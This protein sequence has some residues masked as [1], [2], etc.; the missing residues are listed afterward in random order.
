MVFA[1]DTADRFNA[2]DNSA[3]RTVFNSAVAC[4]DYTAHIAICFI[5]GIDNIEVRYNSRIRNTAEKTEVLGLCR[6]LIVFHINARHRVAVAVK[7]TLVEFDEVFI[8]AV[9]V[10]A[11]RLPYL[12][13]LRKYGRTGFIGIILALI[14]RYIRT[15][16]GVDYS[17]SEIDL[18]CKPHKLVKGGNE[19]I[20]V[21]LY[22]LKACVKRGFALD[23]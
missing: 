5:G 18:V 1:Y 13:V 15:E 20:S 14:Q 11:Y 16:S 6:H 12:S 17:I 9:I 7:L 21:L 8:V 2:P 22:G 19:I 23:R 4:A 3:A 10:A